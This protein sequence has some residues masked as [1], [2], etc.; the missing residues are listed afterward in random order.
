[1]L[2]IKALIFIVYVKVKRISTITMNIYVKYLYIK[3][4]NIL[5]YIFKTRLSSFLKVGQIQS[6]L[7]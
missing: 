2:Y 1:M 5:Y 4:Y 7:C 3:I 6:K